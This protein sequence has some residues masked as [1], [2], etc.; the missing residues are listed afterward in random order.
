MVERVEKVSYAFFSYI[1]FGFVSLQ[2]PELEV[3]T[4]HSL[5]I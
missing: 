4:A 3:T 1:K 5:V 2:W